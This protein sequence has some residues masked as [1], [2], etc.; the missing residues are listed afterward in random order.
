MILAGGSKARERAFFRGMNRTVLWGFFF[1]TLSVFSGAAW[2][3]LG[4]G[5]PVV[6]DDPAMAT[7]MA[8]WLFYSLVLH[9]H[10]TR[11]SS[12]RA[13]AF[14]C[15][16]GALFVFCFTCVPELG[17]FRVPGWQLGGLL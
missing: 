1:W 13:R 8:A 7:T 14:A 2:S 12:I 15:V 17:P 6:W 5:A 9:L 16:F 3:W 11:F 10:L 4:W